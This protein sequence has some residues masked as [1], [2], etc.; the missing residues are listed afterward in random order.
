M[1]WA[2]NVGEL[3][4]RDVLIEMEAELEGINTALNTPSV[5]PGEVRAF[6]GEVPDGWEQLGVSG[7]SGYVPGWAPAPSAFLSAGSKSIDT[8]TAFSPEDVPPSLV[9]V[10]PPGGPYKVLLEGG[11][12]TQGQT[13]GTNILDL[14]T[15]SITKK[16][17]V[18][19]A[20]GT[21]SHCSIRERMP[22]GD[23]FLAGGVSSSPTDATNFTRTIS[24]E[25]VI[26]ALAP[27]SIR[28]A[29]GAGGWV[30]DGVLG[31]FS[32]DAGANP[33]SPSLASQLYTVATN[34]WTTVSDSPTSHRSGV[35][36]S[37]NGKGYI[38]GGDTA[39]NSR[40]V[41]EFD[42]DTGTYTV[43]PW[44]WPGNVT[45]LNGVSCAKLANGKYLV[46]ARKAEFSNSGSLAGAAYHLL[47]LVGPDGPEA[48]VPTPMTESV[49][50]YGGGLAATGLDGG[51]PVLLTRRYWSSSTYA[52]MNFTLESQGQ[53]FLSYTQ[54]KYARKLQ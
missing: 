5:L 22:N 21:G 14:S 18:A 6:M 39:A 9:M 42:P 3:G 32:C 28:H 38:I 15:G 34:T 49:S 43:M 25:G 47:F 11:T 12:V 41:H 40:V 24:P 19:G 17:F 48:L 8:G 54:I 7:V 10:G 29:N 31:F 46:H 27:A 51:V 26:T 33:M 52:E 30:R 45:G 2:S 53:E 44:V 37:F 23:A 1:T 4:V 35:V 36:I 13:P 50:G 16:P 20:G